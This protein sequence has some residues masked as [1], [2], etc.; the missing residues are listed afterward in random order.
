[1][2]VLFFECFQDEL[3]AIRLAP[4]Y[5]AHV[6]VSHSQQRSSPSPWTVRPSKFLFPFILS[7]KLLVFMQLSFTIILCP[8]GFFN[9]SLE[10]CFHFIQDFLCGLH[11]ADRPADGRQFNILYRRRTLCLSCSTS[12]CQICCVWLCSTK[13]TYARKQNQTFPPPLMLN[14]TRSSN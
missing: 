11:Q 13:W 2:S 3:E 5:L 8:K 12:H 14:K 4:K 7:L 10:A 6:H 1:M 9:T